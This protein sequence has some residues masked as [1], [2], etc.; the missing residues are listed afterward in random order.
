MPALANKNIGHPRTFEFQINHKKIPR[1]TFHEIFAHTYIKEVLVVYLNSNVTD[2]LAFSDSP[3][4]RRAEGCRLLPKNSLE[5]PLEEAAPL[6]SCLGTWQAGQDWGT[7]TSTG[8][9]QS[10]GD[11]AEVS[12]RLIFG[13]R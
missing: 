3:R 4:A 12:L 1:S 11:G 10:E 2:R 8:T 7:V 13:P 5:A 9:A 6:R